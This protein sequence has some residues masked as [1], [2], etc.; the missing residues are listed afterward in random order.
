MA[1]GVHLLSP[2]HQNIVLFC[3]LVGAMLWNGCREKHKAKILLQGPDSTVA[4]ASTLEEYTVRVSR[5]DNFRGTVA[6]FA[7]TNIGYIC[8]TV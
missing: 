4:A 7:G 2:T 5:V 8:T 1:V 3:K 6:A